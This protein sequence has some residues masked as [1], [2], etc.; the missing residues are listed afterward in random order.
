MTE[1]VTIIEAKERFKQD[2]GTDKEA[3]PPTFS[4]DDCPRSCTASSSSQT[5]AKRAW[6]PPTKRSRL[7]VD[8]AIRPKFAPQTWATS[9]MCSTKGKRYDRA[10]H[11]H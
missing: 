1:H 10:C 9:T 11:H 3:K 4:E 6:K 5:A 8:K 7:S 2:V